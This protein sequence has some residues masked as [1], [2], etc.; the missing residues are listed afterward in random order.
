MKS[1]LK[2]ELGRNNL[3]LTSSLSNFTNATGAANVTSS[4]GNVAFILLPPVKMPGEYE[5]VFRIIP[6]NYW[7]DILGKPGR[8]FI[9]LKNKKNEFLS[10][11]ETGD[12]TLS[13]EFTLTSLWSPRAIGKNNENI[14]SLQNFFGGYMTVNFLSGSVNC[15]PRKPNGNSIFKVVF[16]SSENLDLY[17]MLMNEGFITFKDNKIYT[18]NKLKKDFSQFFFGVRNITEIPTE[19]ETVT[20]ASVE[21]LT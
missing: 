18:K 11:N 21:V 15:F 3:N 20:W 17:L 5:D 2:M 12:V 4:G 16:Y 6:P 9:I 1:K 13:K 10:C 8:D 7:V 14:V 19:K